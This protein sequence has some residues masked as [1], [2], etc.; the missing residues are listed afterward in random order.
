MVGFLQS[1][2][3]GTNG[4]NPVGI[5]IA[6]VDESSSDVKLFNDR[7]EV[8]VNGD[9]V[10]EKTLLSLADDAQDLEPYLK[11]NGFQDFAYEVTGDHIEIQAKENS[12]QM[13][14]ILSSYLSIK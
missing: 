6:F 4:N 2:I 1:N 3:I 7:Y 11:D 8:F 14:E 13:K 5:P 9:K 10:G 12:H